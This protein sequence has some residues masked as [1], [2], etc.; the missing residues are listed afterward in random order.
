MPARPQFF[1]TTA[2][3]PHLDGRHV[4]FG[5][6]VEVESL[7]FQAVGAGSGSGNVSNP[8]TVTLE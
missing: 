7:V 2:A 3:A 5:K 8:V 6:V 4:V 1:I